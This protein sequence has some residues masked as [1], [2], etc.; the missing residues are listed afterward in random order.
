MAKILLHV[1]LRK[2]M[3]GKEFVARLRNNSDNRTVNMSTVIGVFSGVHDE[4][5]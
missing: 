5:L 1:H 2:Q 3:L 4:G